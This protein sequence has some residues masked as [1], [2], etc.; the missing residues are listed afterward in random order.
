MSSFN[1]DDKNLGTVSERAFA[2]N[3]SPSVTLSLCIKIHD[4]T[5]KNLLNYIKSSICYCYP[6]SHV[7]LVLIGSSYFCES[8]IFTVYFVNVV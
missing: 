8:L 1:K 4:A 6:V 3:N 5:S 2:R 7:G